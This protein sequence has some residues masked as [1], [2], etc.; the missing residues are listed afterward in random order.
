MGEPLKQAKAILADDH[1]MI[2][3][4][5][6]QILSDLEIS[7][8]AEA[9]DGLQ[10]IAMVRAMQP[11]L[12]ILD[13]AMPHARGIEVF[14][15]ARRWSPDTKV[16]VLSGVTAA[17]V[18]EG[19]VAAGAEGIFLKSGDMSELA[20]AIPA[21]LEGKTV[22]GQEVTALLD[23]EETPD[24]L[25]LREREVLSMISNGLTNR[26][27]AERLGVSIK[28]VDNHRT[29]LMRKVDAHSIADLFAY[30][31]RKGLLD[32]LAKD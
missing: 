5:L 23:E 13:V 25:T 9:G 31:M 29:N 20:T 4:A 3:Q 30:A 26:Q 14:A 22:V 11:D 19:F 18:F 2:R 28:T 12:L 1:P 24:S 17:G 15:E 10:A 8:V 27:I 7:V 6:R 21:I 32:G 16:L